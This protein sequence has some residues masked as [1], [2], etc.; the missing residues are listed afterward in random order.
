MDCADGASVDYASAECVGDDGAEAARVAKTAVTLEE[1]GLAVVLVVVQAAARAAAMG[2]GVTVAAMAVAMVV[3]ET[4][5][6]AREVVTV[7][8]VVAAT[9][10][11]WPRVPQHA[12]AG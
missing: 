7:V 3:A 1:A 6:A 5:A 9:A 8:T 12:I 4:G 11:D 2:A 10:L